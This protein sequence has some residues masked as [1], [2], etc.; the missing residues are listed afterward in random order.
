MTLLRIPG[1]RARLLHDTPSGEIWLH[2]VARMKVNKERAPLLVEAMFTP[3]L[4]VLLSI[5]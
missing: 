1:A 3:L 5:P 4:H 2:T